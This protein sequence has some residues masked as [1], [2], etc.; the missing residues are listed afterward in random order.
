MN[1]VTDTTLLE[2]SNDRY[3]LVRERSFTS[4]HNDLLQVVLQLRAE[5]VTGTMT[6]DFSQGGI[7]RV[8]F[9]EEQDIRYEEK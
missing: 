3:R 9:R 6:I 4:S 1:T 8:R 7:N 5:R 2:T